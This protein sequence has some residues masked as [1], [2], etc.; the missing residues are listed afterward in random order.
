MDTKSNQWR[1]NEVI[2]AVQECI[3]TKY[4]SITKRKTMTANQPSDQD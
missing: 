3:P 2:G 1:F 4:L